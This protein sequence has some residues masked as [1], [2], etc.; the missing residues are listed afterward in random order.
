MWRDRTE[1]IRDTYAA[2]VRIDALVC[3]WLHHR[4]RET[5]HDWFVCV[6]VI[7]LQPLKKS[8][9]RPFPEIRGLSQDKGQ[10]EVNTM[11]GREGQSFFKLF[12][13]WFIS[14]GNARARCSEPRILK[15]MCLSPNVHRDVQLQ[16]FCQLLWEQPEPVIQTN[17]ENRA[18]NN[19][20]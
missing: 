4:K 6:H 11:P 16:F 3:L 12:K 10:Y 1:S 7:L 18:R 19:Y 17:F 20:V 14:G 9:M 5:N 8:P 13:K 15:Q 2:D